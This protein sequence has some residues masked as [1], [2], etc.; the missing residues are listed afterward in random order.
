MNRTEVELYGDQPRWETE[1]DRS[2][3]KKVNKY[4]GESCNM[5]EDNI[6][7]FCGR[8][9]VRKYLWKRFRYHVWSGEVFRLGKNKHI[10]WDYEER[11][12]RGMRNGA[13]KVWQ[14]LV[15]KLT[16][17][18]RQGILPACIV[19]VTKVLFPSPTGVYHGF[20]FTQMERDMMEPEY[21]Y[22]TD[23]EEGEA[24]IAAKRLRAMK[25]DPVP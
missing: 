7:R 10:E 14:M 1:T 19:Q 20:P 9:C 15:D 23:E 13:Y 4:A 17:N 8:Y 18:E 12:N 25:H 22:E 24:E 21:W 3:V 5:H 6:C 2:L 11:V 16:K